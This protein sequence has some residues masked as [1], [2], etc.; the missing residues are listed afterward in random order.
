ML[1]FD[2][3]HQNKGFLAFEI[4]STK[5]LLARPHQTSSMTPRW[6]QKHHGLLKAVFLVPEVIRVAY[7]PTCLK[8]ENMANLTA[9]PHLLRDVREPLTG[10]PLRVAATF[11]VRLLPKLAW[12]N[13]N[14]DG[15]MFKVL[16]N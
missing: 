5:I 13:A 4:T 3:M 10:D 14:F 15:A 12:R 2:F 7:A 16:T 9:R 8:V 11:V 6:S 1:V